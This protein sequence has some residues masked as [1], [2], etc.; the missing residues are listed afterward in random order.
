MQEIQAV[1]LSRC[2][3][4]C[5]RKTINQIKS[6]ETNIISFTFFPVIFG[7]QIG[8]IVTCYILVSWYGI[9]YDYGKPMDF[10]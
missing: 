3:A 5:F 9:C 2:K 10:I 1:S 4:G 7:L 6:D 8:L